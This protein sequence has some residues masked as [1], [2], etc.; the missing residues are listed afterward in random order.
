MMMRSSL[1][2][3]LLYASALVSAAPSSTISAD[4]LTTAAGAKSSSVGTVTINGTPTTYSVAFTVPAEADVGP[5]I[6]PNIYDP[7]AKVAQDLCPGYKATNIKNTTTGMTASLTLAG[8]AV[9]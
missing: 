8:S 9:C 5:N 1:M 6:L 2:Q 4:G 3:A 7:K